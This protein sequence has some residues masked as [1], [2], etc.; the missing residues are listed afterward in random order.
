MSSSGKLK[1]YVV[2]LKLFTIVLLSLTQL[3]WWIQIF[4]IVEVSY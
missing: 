1:M 4:W 2:V 3:Q